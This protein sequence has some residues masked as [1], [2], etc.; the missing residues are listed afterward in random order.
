MSKRFFIL[1]GFVFLGIQAVFCSTISFEIVQKS[2]NLKE[3][4]EA[5][6]VFEDELMNCFFDAGYI[7]SNSP[8]VVSSSD[9][10]DELFFEKALAQAGEG[11]SDYFIQVKLLFKNLKEEEKNVPSLN[12]IEKVSWKIVSVKNGKTINNGERKVLGKKNF[13]SELGIRDFSATFCADLIKFVNE[14][15]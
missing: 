9:A 2:G 12:Q 15:G 7:A 11:F 14:K 13:D 8:A 10:N 3:L 4:C 1:F 6:L 5:S